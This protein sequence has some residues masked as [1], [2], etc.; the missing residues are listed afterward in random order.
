MHQ[1]QVEFQVINRQSGEPK[2]QPQQGILL[3]L[4]EETAVVA[5]LKGEVFS[6]MFSSLRIIM[7]T[8]EGEK[9]AKEL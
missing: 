3:Q 5:N 4:F 9:D 6:I 7:P 1:Y 8:I 2:G